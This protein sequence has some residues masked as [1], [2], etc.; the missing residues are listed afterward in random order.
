M[1]KKEIYADADVSV[2]NPEAICSSAYTLKVVHTIY[3]RAQ[4]QY[5]PHALT[6][7]ACFSHITP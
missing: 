2:A 5:H 7:V 4:T 6:H 1:L 3:E